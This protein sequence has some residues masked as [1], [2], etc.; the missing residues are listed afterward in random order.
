MRANTMKRT[1][2]SR[3]HAGGV[4]IASILQRDNP[5]GLGTSSPG[6][7]YNLVWLPI[8]QP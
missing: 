4:A 3:F 8:T 5:E 7:L 6:Q 2:F 1:F